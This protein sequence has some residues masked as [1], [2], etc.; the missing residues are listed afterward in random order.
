[1]LLV[2]CR[3]PLEPSRPDRAFGAEVAAIERLGLPYVLV[4][5]DALVGDDDPGRAV[6]RVPEQAEPVL[7]A[8]RGWMVTPR[9]YRAALRGPRRQGHPP[10]Q[11]PRPVPA[12][13][14]P[15]RELPGHRGAHATVGL[16]D[17]RPG[18]RPD[19]GGPGP[20]RGRPGRRQGL[21]EEPEARVGR[22][23]LHPLGS[24][25]GGGR[26]GRR[27]VPRTPGRGPRRG[28]G[29]PGVRRVRADRRPPEERD[30]ADGGVPHLLARW[31]PGLLGSLLG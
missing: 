13:P 28:P 23:V 20:V 4:D 26:A 2:L 1:M 8:Y 11:R 18:H 9:Q 16:A 3:D 24:R 29:L 5:H 7:A 14:P 19:H 27:A 25:P 31:R 10:D 15:A 30:A 17:R 6:R 22:G 12:R 21:R